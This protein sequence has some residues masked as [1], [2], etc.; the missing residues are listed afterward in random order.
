[1]LNQL[2]Y[3]AIGHPFA[4]ALVGSKPYREDPLRTRDDSENGT[5]AA[6]WVLS[7]PPDSPTD[8]KSQLMASFKL[9]WASSPAAAVRPQADSSLA[10]RLCFARP[11]SLLLLENAGILA[12]PCLRVE[13]CAPNKRLDRR[14]L[15]PFCLNGAH[16]SKNSSSG[17]GQIH[18]QQGRTTSGP[19]RSRAVCGDGTI[20]FFLTLGKLPS[21]C[22][23]CVSHDSP[24]FCWPQRPMS[25]MRFHRVR[26]LQQERPKQP[27]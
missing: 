14:N 22:L 25:S 21:A 12:Q 23:L 5:T 20:P 10:S 13:T 8:A 9:S 3:N 2:S 15:F 11:C 24:E 1:M 7:I 4:Q 18:E 26:R 17:Y 16:M 6:K 19:Q 27:A